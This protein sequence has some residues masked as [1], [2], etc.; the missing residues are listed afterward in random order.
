MNSMECCG[1]KPEMYRT[2]WNAAEK[3]MNCN[4]FS[5]LAGCFST[6]GALYTHFKSLSSK[7]RDIYI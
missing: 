1:G 3:S 7:K 2:V 6:D 4:K 5:G